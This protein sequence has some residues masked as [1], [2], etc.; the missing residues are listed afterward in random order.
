MDENTSEIPK[1]T[2][3]IAEGD[4]EVRSLF[5]YNRTS[6]IG[7]IYFL[8][9]VNR[10]QMHYFIL[11][12]PVYLVHSYM[13]WGIIVMGLLSQLNLMMMSKWFNSSY[14][15]KGYQGFLQLFGKRAVQVFAILGFLIILFKISIITLGYVEM[16]HSFIYPSM[17]KKWLI[18]MIL[19]I[20]LFVASHGMEKTLRF[21]IIAFLCGA[22]IVIMFIPFFFPPIANYRDLYPL[23]PTEWSGQSWQGLLFIWSAFSGPVYLVFMVPWL[24]SNKKI[25][26]YLVIGNM[27]TI[28]EFSLLFIASVLFYGSNFLSKINFPIGYMGSYIQ[29]SGLERIDHI[30]ISFHMFNY[31]FDISIL[32]LSLYGAGRVFMRKMNKGATRIGFLSSWFIILMSIILMDQ[33]LWETIPGQKMLLNIQIWLGA[34]IYLLVPAI[35]FTAVKRKESM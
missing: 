19:L 31:V 6:P 4:E 5:L 24:S 27:L 34:F 10:M 29:T 3:E 9:L 28:I 35:L 18:L 26:K 33:W 32:L 7:G 21:V 25:S 22:W 13:V 30:L 17:N 15:A 14:A 8:F 16:L 20:S 12:M 2:A 11:I 1:T 23:I